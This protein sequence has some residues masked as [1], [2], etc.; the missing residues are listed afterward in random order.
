MKNFKQDVPPQQYIIF[1][2][3]ILQYS[4]SKHTTAP[5]I[6]YLS[7]VIGRG[8]GLAISEITIFEL[9]S[10]ATVKQ[11]RARF[12]TLSL[13]KRYKISEQVL[14]GAAQLATLYQ[15]ENILTQNISTADM[16]I[17]A[18]AILTGSLVMTANVNDFPRPFFREAE[19]RLINY[20]YKNRP[21]MIPVC[22]LSPN[23][24][25][26]SKRFGERPK[27]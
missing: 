4:T 15:R 7:D 18:T 21:R 16:I 27:G 14:V 11:E 22:L 8:F 2:T 5:F 24:P 9:L 10:G 13:F 25:V 23:I 20:R 17:A 12:Q 19:E 1:D 3:N 6:Q 26:I